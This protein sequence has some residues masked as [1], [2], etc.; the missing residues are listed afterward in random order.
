MADIAEVDRLTADL[1]QQKS[2]EDLEELAGRLMDGTEDGLATFVGEFT[3]EGDD[4]PG[5]L[6][7]QTGGGLV[8]EEKEARLKDV[9]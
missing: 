3:E 4:S 2:V 6:R 5:T 9:R 8:K 1:Q 7:I